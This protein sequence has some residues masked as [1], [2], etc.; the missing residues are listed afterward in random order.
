MG[1]LYLPGSLRNPLIEGK[2]REKQMNRRNFLRWLGG[3][4]AGAA[5][6]HVLD[7]DRLLW[8]PGE[9]TIFLPTPE[10]MSFVI[11]EWV[12]MDMLRVLKNQLVVADVFNRAYDLEGVGVVNV[13]I[14]GR[15]T[16]GVDNGKG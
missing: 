14:R 13:P 9:R 1:D 2:N 6:A 10:E 15:W 16:K 4:A 5:A 8:V 11:P 12:A 3:T 7:V